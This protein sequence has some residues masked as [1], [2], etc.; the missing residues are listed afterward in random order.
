[1]LCSRNGHVHSPVVSEETKILGPY[2]GD[3]DDVLLSAL[4]SI[5]CIHFDVALVIQAQFVLHLLNR[6]FYLP[7]LRLVRRDYSNPTSHWRE[8]AQIVASRRNLF[9]EKE[10][11]FYDKT[12]LILIL[13]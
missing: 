5:H 2:R 1:M 8:I 11:H 10:E 3:N 12:Y 13:L 6:K 9:G 4:V 7:N